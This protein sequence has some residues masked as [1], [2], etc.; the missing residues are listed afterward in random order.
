MLVTVTHLH[1]Q[2]ALLPLVLPPWQWGW[3][4]WPSF[5]SSGSRRAVSDTLRFQSPGTDRVG[6]QESVS[7]DQKIEIDK[8]TDTR[9]S[10]EFQCRR[11]TNCKMQ[12]AKSQSYRKLYTGHIPRAT[13]TKYIVN[14]CSSYSLMQLIYSWLK[15]KK[16]KLL[17]KNLT[18]CQR[19]KQNKNT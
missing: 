14:I 17:I 16:A 12:T 19:H 13:S 3:E 9:K 4:Q 5:C 15:K 11:L 2:W 6:L 18:T 10:W 1:E 7:A 8:Y